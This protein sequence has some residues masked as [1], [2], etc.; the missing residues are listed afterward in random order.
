MYMFLFDGEQIQPK[1]VQKKAHR[2]SGS[3]GG[4][5][6]KRLQLDGRSMAA[7]SHCQPWLLEAAPNEKYSYCH[8]YDGNT[9]LVGPQKSQQGR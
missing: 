5:N 6:A 2:N 8:T 3:Q 9:G 4:L 7:C 1:R